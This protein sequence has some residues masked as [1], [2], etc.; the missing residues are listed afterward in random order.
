MNFSYSEKVIALQEKL[1]DFGAAGVGPDYTLAVQWAN[2]RTLRLADG[3]D[4]VHRNQIAK[5]EMKKH[6]AKTEELI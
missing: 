2:S 5:L 1:Q 3:P 4:E 6:R